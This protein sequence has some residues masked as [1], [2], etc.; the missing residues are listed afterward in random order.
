MPLKCKHQIWIAMKIR[1]IVYILAILLLIGCFV[2][3]VAAE[4]NQT[5]DAGTYFY[6]TGIMLLNSNQYERAISLFNQALASDTTM[7]R[8]SD[9]LLYTYQGKSYALIQL[10]RSEEA[11]ET[12]DEGLKVYPKDAILWN[13]KGYALYNLGKYP[14]ALKSYDA[15]LSIDQNYTPSLVNKG[16]TLYKMGRFTDAVDAYIKANI[17][18]PGNQKAMEGLEK[19]QEAAK[20][21]IPLTSFA[22]IVILA[23]IASVVIYYMKFRKPSKERPIETKTKGKKK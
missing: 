20:S 2:V 9:A 10:N 1:I 14:D 5:P 22:I 16:D 23:I 11:V 18:D 13:N 8:Q 17:T 12:V 19:A 15:V 7:I 21:E 4:E 3:P 6:N